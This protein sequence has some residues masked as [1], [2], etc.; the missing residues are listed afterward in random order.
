MKQHLLT[1]LLTVMACLTGS[2][3]ASALDQVGDVYQIGNA[4][5]LVAFSNLVASGNGGVSAVLTADIDMT[6]VDNFQPIGTTSS[7]FRGTFDGQQ[8]Y[9]MNLMLE[10]PEQEYVGLFGVL[11]GG[12]YIKNVIIDWSCIISGSAFVGGIAGGTNG[13]GT[14]TFENCGNEASVGAQNQNAAGICGVS[15]GSQCGIVMRNCFNT[16]GITG[17]REC[18][19][20]CGWVG[21]SGSTITNCYNA[22]FVIGMDGTNSLWRNGNGKGLNNFD[23][24]GYQG[25]LIS[26]DE[27]DLMWGSV[28]YQINGNQS[29]DVVWFQTVGVDM[30]PVPFSSHGVVYAVGDLYCDGTSKGGDLTFSNSN[31]SNRDPHEFVDGVCKNCGTPDV[32]F[33]TP[34]ADGYYEIASA[35]ELNWLAT[36]VNSGNNKLNARLT[37]DID[38]STYTARDVMIGGDAYSASES[39][40]AR[41]FSGTFDGQGHKVTVNYNVSYDGVA[42]FKVINNATIRNLMVDGAIESTQR[43]IGGL[44]FVSRGASL[45]ENVV[46][47]VNITGSYPGDA[48]DGGFFAVCHEN[49]TFR[50]CGFVGTM[51]APYSEGSA[52]IIGY[53]HGNVETI[54]EN[55]YVA[56]TLLELTGNSTVIARNVNTVLNTFYTDNIVTLYDDR[57]TIVSEQA[58]KSGELAYTINQAVDGNPWRQTLGQDLYPVPFES[59]A[60]VYANGSLSCDGTPKGTLTYSN[61]ESETLRD[62]HQYDASGVCTVCGA[63]LVSNGQQLMAVAEG[64]NNGSISANILIDLDADIDL[65]GFKYEGIGIRFNEA[66]GETDDEGNPTYRDVLRPFEGTFDGHGHRI[67]NML[68]DVEDGNK[69][70]FGLVRGATIRN[71]VVDNT[72]EIY[73]TGY[74]AGIVGTTTGGGV[75]TIENCGNE[76]LVNVGASGAN[77]AGILGVNDL[78]AAYIRIVNCYNTG[79]IIGQRECGAISGWL[80]DRFEV[81]NT[82]NAGTVAPE[83]VDGIRTF[84]RH[85]SGANFTNCYEVGSQQVQSVE[86]DDVASGRL[87]FLLNEG[88]GQTV[89]YQTIGEDEHPVL[90]ATHGV[91]TKSG[92][93]YT[94]G[95]ANVQYSMFNVQSIYDLGGRS[96][97]VM[98]R[99]LNIVRQQDG[100]VRKVLVK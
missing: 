96:H 77:G 20:L 7:P 21:D 87:C 100:T 24:Y 23:S 63:R 88:A 78:S 61:T 26:E 15:M 37:A 67:S 38:F 57:C 74:S 89:F 35:V 43:F 33:L 72:C 48:T 65:S 25:T 42:L 3:R 76:A 2:L 13:G 39:D 82:Y 53:A 40:D 52:A 84:A 50:N 46:V 97:A 62:A 28:C 90:D 12:A 54:I 81:V 36:M 98:Q 60:V 94:N 31:E 73:T 45:I 93:T 17:D 14:V 64:I 66:T 91:V 95:I 27:Y 11:N 22:G 41:A 19:A 92:D 44:G 56:S 58:V 80:G 75:V 34:A 29:D 71:V 18:A 85:N 32:S 6:G 70:L 10:L 69:G 99:G 86:F 47:A 49:V 83:A 8:H 9:I 51:N 16:G 5:D 30:H 4:T 59:H 1:A 55:C 68:I 79:D